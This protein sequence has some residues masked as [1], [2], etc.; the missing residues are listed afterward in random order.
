MTEDTFT[1]DR[2]T[3]LNGHTGPDNAYLIDDYPYGRRLRC[4]RRTWVETAT[5]GR[6]A[7]QQRF[8]SQT[9]NPKQGGAWNKPHAGTY[10]LLV[11]MYLDSENHVGH[12]KLSM[13]TYPSAIARMQHMGIDEQLTGHQ[14]AAWN[15]L[16]SISQRAKRKWREWN[17]TVEALADHIRA[18]GS[19]PEISGNTWQ[20]FEKLHYL[21]Y[22]VAAHVISARERAAQAPA[23]NPPQEDNETVSEA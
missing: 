16:V 11:V 4:K 17:E 6:Y 12:Q 7:G 15:S 23:A 19:D 9:T 5:K 8:V 20:G 13:L 22:D 3:V 2:V 10:A 1:I 14:R 18:T 21:G